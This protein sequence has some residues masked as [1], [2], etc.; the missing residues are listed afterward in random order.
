MVNDNIT[1]DYT[2]RTSLCLTIK[3]QTNG[4]DIEIIVLKTRKW[5]IMSFSANHLLYKEGNIIYIMP[6][7][8]T[9]NDI[10][11]TVLHLIIF[12]VYLFGPVLESISSIMK[13][14]VKCS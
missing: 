8:L 6:S 2:T 1:N 3:I 4:N 9:Y 11:I 14:N 5:F 12:V 13:V 7:R 10:T